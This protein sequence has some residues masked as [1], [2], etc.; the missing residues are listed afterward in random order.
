MKKNLVEGQDYV[1]RTFDFLTA[2]IDGCCVSDA[3]GCCTIAL[4]ERVCPAR[5]RK[6]LDHE[7]EH[8]S[9][10]DLYSE[11]DVANIEARRSG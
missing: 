11:E 9:C 4:N 5:R 8:L 2:K 3:D 10:G 6:A 7:L 1:I